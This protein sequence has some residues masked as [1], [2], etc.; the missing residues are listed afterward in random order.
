M[1]N[2]EFKSLKYGD[3]LKSEDNEIIIQGF[4]GDILLFIRKKAAAAYTLDE[5]NRCNYELVKPDIIDWDKPNLVYCGD[6]IVLTTGKHDGT[7]FEGIQIDGEE[8]HCID[9]WLKDSFKLY[10]GDLIKNFKKSI[11]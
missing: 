7:F 10:N 9:S 8:F 1:T 11:K 3:V 2:E 4:V 5:L 6:K